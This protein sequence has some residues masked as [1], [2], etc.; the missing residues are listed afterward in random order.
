MND[1]HFEFS[2]KILQGRI[3]LVTVSLSS[4]PDIEALGDDGSKLFAA[5]RNEHQRGTSD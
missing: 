2:G 4:I 5:I 3:P 1:Y